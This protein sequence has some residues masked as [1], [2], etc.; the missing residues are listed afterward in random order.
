VDDTKEE[1]MRGEGWL[2]QV[3][4][5]CWQQQQMMEHFIGGGGNKSGQGQHLGSWVADG[6][7]WWQQGRTGGRD[8]AAAATASGTTLQRQAGVGWHN[9]REE[10]GRGQCKA[11][12]AGAFLFSFV[13]NTVARS[14]ICQVAAVRAAMPAICNFLEHPP[15]CPGTPPPP[16]A[17]RGGGRFMVAG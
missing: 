14:I 13:S 17:E 1:E 3:V 2:T 10:S 12:G 7:S 5:S 15:G 4:D 6:C 8:G 11:I 9:K 16:G